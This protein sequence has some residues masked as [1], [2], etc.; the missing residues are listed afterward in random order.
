MS[1]LS[2]FGKGKNASA[3]SMLEGD[4]GLQSAR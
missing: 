3:I 4:A 1:A 2:L